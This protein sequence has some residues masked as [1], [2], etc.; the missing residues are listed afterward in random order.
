[1]L[2][3]PQFD[4]VA[5]SLGPIQVHWY[6]LMYLLA[7]LG[8]YGLAWYRMKSQAWSP[9]KTSEQLGDVLFYIALG[10]I[11]GGRCG[12][13]LFYDLP[14]FIHAPWIIFKVWDG[15]MSFHGGLIG[16]TLAMFFL[17]RKLSVPFLRLTDFIAPF[18]PLGLGLGRLGNFINGELWGRITT[19]KLGMIFPTGGPFP[20]YPS[21]LFELILEGVVLFTII[22]IFSLKPRK[23]GAISGL[24][25][26]LYACFRF[27]IEFYREP[28][29][30]LGYLAFG[31]LT[32]GQVL[33]IPMFALAVYLLWRSHRQSGL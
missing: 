18:A 2:H 5:L 3:Y 7:F 10:V 28:D 13:M 16:V 15:G 20:R 9:I 19:S 12:Y 30:Q 21:Q 33:C 26:L 6:G 1:M 8:G 11:L 4:P 27:Y 17:S 24:F 22:W 31:W 23:T 14:S 25:L 29:P 32:M